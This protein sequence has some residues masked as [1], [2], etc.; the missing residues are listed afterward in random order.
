MFS[1]SLKNILHRL[2][3]QPEWEQ[4]QQYCEV[5]KCW[6]K[7]TNQKIAYNTQ[8][9]FISRQILWVATSSS[10]W[11]QEL[12]LQ[13]YSLLKKLN[14][15]LTFTI[16]DI[17]FSPGNWTESSL[18]SQSEAKNHNITKFPKPPILPK[19]KGLKNSPKIDDPQI[20][21]KKWLEKIQNRAESQTQPYL[22]CPQCSSL[23]PIPELERWQVCSH[24]IANKWSLEYRPST[25][26][27]EQ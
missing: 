5:K 11:A 20:A 4:Y 9:K 15:Q 19:I 3:Q 10:V 1:N 22:P 27:K 8:P 21:L 6:Q 14:S 12:S 26:N 25:S 16:T 2:S 13:R 24:C 17:R 23:T 18:T 7:I